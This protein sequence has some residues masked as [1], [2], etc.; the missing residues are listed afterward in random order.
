MAIV[1]T[2]HEP[3]AGEREPLG[4]WSTDQADRHSSKLLDLE[5]SDQDFLSDVLHGLRRPRKKLSC[6]FLYDRRGSEL[7]DRICTL[8]EYYPTRTELQVMQQNACEMVEAIG[9]NCLLIEYGSGSSMKTLLLLECLPR[10]AAYVPIDISRSHLISACKRLNAAYPALEVLPVCGDYT[11]RLRLPAPSRK[12]N[13]RVVYFPGSTIGN[14]VPVQAIQFLRRTRRLVGSG[15]GLLIGVDLKKDPRLLHA[16]YNDSAGVTA[17][18]NLNLL[19]RINREL[20]GTFDLGCFEHYAPYNP[21]RGRIEMHLVS[22]CYQQASVAGETF[23]FNR[24]ETIFSECSYKYTLEEFEELAQRAG[25]RPQFAW[26]DPDELF[27]V[28]YFAAA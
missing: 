15:G 17:E 20:R 1:P 16:A 12:P 14:F 24:G 3:L 7:F 10:P 6:K 11:S 23:E 4:C 19:V 2:T 21:R 9:P 5:P 26:T 8:P 25:Y 27:S 18:F 28:Q 22:S 13:R